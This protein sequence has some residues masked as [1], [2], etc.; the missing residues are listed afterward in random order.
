MNKYHVTWFI[1]DKK[2]KLSG[3]TV[4]AKS[5]TEAIKKVVKKK[6]LESNIKYVIEL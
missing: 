4:E 6:I 2:T 1:D 3:L 5:I